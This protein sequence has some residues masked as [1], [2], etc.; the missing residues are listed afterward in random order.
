MAA[1]DQ[2]SASSSQ[3]AVNSGPLETLEKGLQELDTLTKNL[4]SGQLSIDDAIQLYTKGMKLAAS[5]DKKLNELKQK[6]TLAQQQYRLDTQG[7]AMPAGTTAGG[8]NPVR[9]GSGTGYVQP[10]QPN[11][12]NWQQYPGQGG[13]SSRGGN[14]WQRQ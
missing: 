5:C 4:E 2:I 9:S 14:G 6:V 13:Y 1:N 7:T 10:S 3:A 11:P 12:A 8:V